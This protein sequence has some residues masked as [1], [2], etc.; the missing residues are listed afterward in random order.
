M[1]GTPRYERYSKRRLGR[2]A[3]R[4]WLICAE[5]NRFVWPGPDLRPISPHKPGEL[6]YG[7]LP[8]AF[9]RMVFERLARLRTERNPRVILRSP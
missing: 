4:S 7:V 5:L 1:T 3:E 8:P 2:D 6:A 9:V